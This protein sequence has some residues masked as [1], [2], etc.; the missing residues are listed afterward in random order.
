MSTGPTTVSDILLQ[1]KEEIVFP[2]PVP[3]SFER[4]LCPDVRELPPDSF[5]ADEFADGVLQLVS[6]DG[7]DSVEA[8]KSAVQRIK[9]AERG[10]TFDELKP[11]FVNS[12]WK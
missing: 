9:A 3:N 8:A 5:T 11:D 1:R 12:R 4:S 2:D 6:Q 10:E 7:I